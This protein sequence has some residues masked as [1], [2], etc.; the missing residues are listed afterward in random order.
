MDDSSG[1]IAMAAITLQSVMLQT[2]VADGVLTLE[3]AL[4]L[5]DRAKDTFIFAAEGEI[6]DPAKAAALTCL[7]NVR[8]G[9]VAM[10]GEASPPQVPSEPA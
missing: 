10:F 7:A 2:L 6:P 4:Q 5:V 1:G 3:D 8:D 9:L